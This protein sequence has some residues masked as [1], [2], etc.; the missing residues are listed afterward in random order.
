META[1]LSSSRIDMETV[2]LADGRRVSALTL[3]LGYLLAG[4]NH[5]L[6]VMMSAD[7]ARDLAMALMAAADKTAPPLET[8]PSH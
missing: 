3:H 5:R 7:Q 2:T 4:S 8:P 1:Q 6:P